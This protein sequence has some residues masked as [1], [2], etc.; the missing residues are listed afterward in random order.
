MVRFGLI[1]RL[2]IVLA[3]FARRYAEL[4][5]E[6]AAEMP[7]VIEPPAERHVGDRH[8]GKLG[9]LKIK[10]APLQSAMPDVTGEAFTTRLKQFLQIA[11]GEAF[12]L[13]NLG[14]RQIWI[15]QMRFYLLAKTLQ[16][17]GL[18][19][20]WTVSLDAAGVLDETGNEKF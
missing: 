4:F 5:L 19:A 2:R 6:C 20:G 7:C 17:G 8:T 9:I 12:F 18:H 14:Q 15:C 3:I 10:A 11:R 13:G 1:V 16:H